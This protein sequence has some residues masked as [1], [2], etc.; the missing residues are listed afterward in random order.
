MPINFSSRVSNISSG[1]PHFH[2]PLVLEPLIKNLPWHIPT[3]MWGECPFSDVWSENAALTK[4]LMKINSNLPIL[5]YGFKFILQK[6]YYQ[7]MIFSNLPLK[8]QI[9]VY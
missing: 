5:Y 4:R 7:N 9:H 3:K 2:A 8:Y 1:D 6:K